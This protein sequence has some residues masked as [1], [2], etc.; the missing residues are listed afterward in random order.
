MGCFFDYTS[1]SQ[2][3]FDPVGNSS[4]AYD[5][6]EL[7]YDAEV[8]FASYDPFCKTHKLYQSLNEKQNSSLNN[9]L[10]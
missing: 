4:S 10:C 8:P 6:M 5:C 1:S 9:S 7:C 3:I 2:R